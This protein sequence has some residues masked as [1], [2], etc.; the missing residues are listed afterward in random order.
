MEAFRELA[1]EDPET[2]RLIRAQANALARIA[3]PDQHLIVM[4]RWLLKG[5]PADRDPPQPTALGH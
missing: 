4:V 3:H 2:A 1:R 5:L